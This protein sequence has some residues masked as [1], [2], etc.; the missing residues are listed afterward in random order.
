MQVTIDGINRE[1]KETQYGMKQRIGLKIVESKVFD[2]N[3]TEI[4]VNDRWFN[5]M[6]ALT[7]NGT[8]SWKKGDKVNIAITQKEGKYLNFKV[9]RDESAPTPAH[10]SQ[11][12]D[13]V[14]ADIYAR[15]ATVESQLKSLLPAE[16]IPDPTDDF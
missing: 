4:P 9:V 16:V 7:N 5:G 8:E 10:T 15:L 2:I 12:N 6:V 11:S 3:G 1:E 14:V 13:A